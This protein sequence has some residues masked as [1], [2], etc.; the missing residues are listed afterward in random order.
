MKTHNYRKAAFK[1]EECDFVSGNEWSM[2]VHHGR[3]H[4]EILECGL[5]D[6]VAKDSDTLD[7]HLVTCEI[8]ECDLCEDKTKN[9]SELKH[10]LETKHP[11]NS[12]RDSFATHVKLDRKH[13]NEA[14][15]KCHKIS[16]LI[17][18]V[19]DTGPTTT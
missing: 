12:L 9:L 3:M 18:S 15:F 19:S 7:L 4:T 5:C 16:E 1:C 11:D 17:S 6:F 8:Y 2:E 10:H 13:E 14:S